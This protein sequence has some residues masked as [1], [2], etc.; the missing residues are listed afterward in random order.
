[1]NTIL[2]RRTYNDGEYP[3][4]VIIGVIKTEMDSS[5][6]ESL[7]VDWKREV[8]QSDPESEFVDWLI[9]HGYAIRKISFEVAD[10]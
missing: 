2:I 6:I 3:S 10:V 1:M 8:A 5:A 7:W 4:S 9:D